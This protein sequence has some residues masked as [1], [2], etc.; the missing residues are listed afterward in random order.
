MVKHKI[1]S[2]LKI[3]CWANQ[4]SVLNQAH[5]MTPAFEYIFYKWVTLYISSFRCSLS[6]TD[7]R[8]FVVINFAL[9]I[10]TPI[11]RIFYKFEGL[12]WRSMP[13]LQFPFEFFSECFYVSHNGSS[14]LSIEVKTIWFPFGFQ[15]H[16]SLEILSLFQLMKWSMQLGWQIPLHRHTTVCKK[17]RK[18]KWS[19]LMYQK[20][21]PC[22]QPVK[23]NLSAFYT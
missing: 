14:P 16:H 10:Y 2:Y 20:W 21:K 1:A 13:I 18:N 19:W 12:K 11:E 9:C 8:Y 5:S 3:A 7:L 4:T 15:A 17:A 23:S 22:T 6:L